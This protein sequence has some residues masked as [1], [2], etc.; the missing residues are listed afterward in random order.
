MAKHKDKERIVKAAREK[1]LE[2]NLEQNGFELH[3][4]TYMWIFFNSKYYSATKTTVGRIHR[5]RNRDM[6][7]LWLWKNC[8]CKQPTLS[9][10]Q[11]FDCTEGRQH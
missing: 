3:K 9:Y 6:E 4:A 8:G 1:Q 5:C 2:L 7:K 11:T 10:T